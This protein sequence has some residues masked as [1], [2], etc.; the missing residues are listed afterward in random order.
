MKVFFGYELWFDGRWV[1]IIYTDRTPT[2]LAKESIR[3]H[4]PW[5]QL[6]PDD[7]MFSIPLLQR[8]YPLDTDKAL[9][10]ELIERTKQE[11]M[12]KMARPVEGFLTSQGKFFDTEAKAN[13]FETN[14]M[15]R[16]ILRDQF[17]AFTPE[18]ITSILDLIK[19][20]H[21]LVSE[22]IQAVKTVIGQTQ[23]D[24]QGRGAT[25]TAQGVSEVRDEVD[26]QTTVDNPPNDPPLW[27][28]EGIQ[29]GDEAVAEAAT[30]DDGET[31]ELGAVRNPSSSSKR[32]KR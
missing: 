23:A 24:G 15:L 16:D 27:E 3:E 32:R 17:S 20:H 8:L 5:I 22:Y 18:T 26:G 13:L 11:R 30:V 12:K 14:L 4:T 7:V 29:V 2:P 6:H 21:E 1:P 25:G 9:Q 19:V 10:N 31:V 28:Q